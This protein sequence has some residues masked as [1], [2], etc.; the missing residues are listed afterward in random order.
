MVRRSALLLVIVLAA[1]ARLFAAGTFVTYPLPKTK[2]NKPV[3]VHAGPDGHMWFLDESGFISRVN[4]DLS[5]TPFKLNASSFTFGADGALWFVGFSQLN[6]LDIYTGEVSPS[7]TFITGLSYWPQITSGSDGN[8]WL[9]S[10]CADKLTRI[11]LT[12]VIREF[13]TTSGGCPYRIIPGPDGNLWFTEHYGNR[14]GRMTTAGVLAEFPVGDY[15]YEYPDDITVGSDGNLYFTNNGGTLRRITPSGV[16]T[17]STSSI[18]SFAEIAT[19]SDGNLWAGRGD[20]I[21]IYNN[22]MQFLGAHNLPAGT[23]FN[24]LAKG[25]DGNI[26][27]SGYGNSTIQRITPGGVLTPIPA[28]VSGG[29]PVGLVL[30]PDGNFWFTETTANKIGRITPGGVVTE[31]AVPEVNSQPTSIVAGSDGALW[32]LESAADQVGRISTAGTITQYALTPGS[33]LNDLVLGSDG[34][35]WITAKTTNKIVRLTMGGTPT[36]YPL[37]AGTTAPAAIVKGSD[38][39]LWFVAGNKIGRLGT[40]GDY[41]EFFHG[42]SEVGDLTLDPLSGKVMMLGQFK[43]YSID[44]SGVVALYRDSVGWTNM[45]VIADAAGTL[46][47]AD[48]GSSNITRVPAA[49]DVVRYNL[50]IGGTVPKALAI[51]PDGDIWFTEQYGSSISKLMS[52]FDATPVNACYTG[53]S[54][55]GT[56]ARIT[57]LAAPASALGYSASIDWGDG[58]AASTA[59]IVADGSFFRVNGSHTYATT[60]THVVKTTVADLDAPSDTVTITSTVRSQLEATVTFTQACASAP[61]IATVTDL[62]PGAYYTWT[63]PGAVLERNGN[64]VKFSSPDPSVT[65]SVVITKAGWCEVTATATVSPANCRVAHH[66]TVQA[67]PTAIAGTPVSV[68]VTAKDQFDVLLETYTGTV[69]FSS[70]DAT[71]SLPANYTFT[72]GDAGTHAFAATFTKVGAKTIDVF[73]VADASITGQA[74]LTVGPGPAASMTLAAPATAGIGL[75]RSIG[76]TLYDAYQNLATTY[77]GTL[78]VTSNDPAA[79]LPADYTFNPATDNGAHTFDVVLRTAGQRTVTFTDTAN[80]SLTRSAPITVAVMLYRDLD[81]DGH[82]DILWRNNSGANSAWLMNGPAFGRGVELPNVAGNDWKIVGAADFNGDGKLDIVWRHYAGYN[83]IWYMDGA[84]NIGVKELKTVFDQNWQIEATGDIN[85]DGKA[86]LIWHNHQNGNVTVWYWDF[87]MNG[88]A[89]AVTT[90]DRAADLN[91]HVAGSGDFDG[92]GDEDLLWRHA[93]SGR[94]VIWK[95]QNAQ[96]QIGEEIP[97]V[98]D[99]NWQIVALGDYTRDGMIDLV[100]RNSQTGMDV[101]WRMN[102]TALAGGVEFDGVN[103]ITGWKI[104]GPK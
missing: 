4:D 21:S 45:Q 77:A 35:L 7:P 57:D 1:A 32:F 60:G 99:L 78:H 76:V 98:S 46:W 56:V 63:V 40:G 82:A 19:G 39:K 103:P 34:A 85:G 55:T 2:A 48:G 50:P 96:L 101:I 38:N 36:Y 28:L 70:N 51:G 62:G 94:N 16:V 30:G 18:A 97:G 27:I 52:R 20:Q 104:V 10:G 23:T 68:T 14:V 42:L 88:V 29:D 5:I 3:E 80:A 44:T 72:G 87:F 26:W 66:F 89:S 86:D 6:R 17:A 95:L 13:P 67:G 9:V 22:S 54:F 37:P 79:T 33:G 31:Y 84:T 25:A 65:A 47:L 43:I 75:T 91:W 15:A 83:A 59:T 92:D 90:I 8:L 12:G 64:H 81:G 11:T 74:A 100:W 24:D 69:S 73:A 49:G 93:V 41:A 61:I 71:A 53:T 58:S 102:H